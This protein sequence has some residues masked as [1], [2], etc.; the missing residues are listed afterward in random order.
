ME[1]AYKA[2]EPGFYTAG[3]EREKK[4]IKKWKIYVKSRKHWEA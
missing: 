4:H 1:N 3:G 2:F